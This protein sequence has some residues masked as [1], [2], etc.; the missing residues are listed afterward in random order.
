MHSLF[1]CVEGQLRGVVK[2]PERPNASPSQTRLIAS[3]R[4]EDRILFA[5]KTRGALS[6]AALARLMAISVPGVRQHLGRLAIAGLVEH[7]DRNEGVGRPAKHWSLTRAADG[8]FP[9]THADLTREMID[10]I[11]DDLGEAALASVVAHRHRRMEQ[12]YRALLGKARSVADRLE[13]LAQARS[14]DGYMASVERDDRGLLLVENHCPICAAAASCQGFCEGELELFR[15]LLPGTTVERIDHALAGA[16][17]CAY[18]ITKN[19]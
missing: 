12:R 5:L 11:R 1:D 8:R 9:D 10:A 17:R 19:R 3:D 18:R 4:T 7:V 16:R 2:R 15:E 6:T 13:R 14:A